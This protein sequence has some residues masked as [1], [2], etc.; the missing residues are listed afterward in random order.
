MQVFNNVLLPHLGVV[1]GIHAVVIVKDE[2]LLFI[3]YF[4]HDTHEEP[5]LIVI[6]GVE[7]HALF[8]AQWISVM[9]RLPKPILIIIKVCVS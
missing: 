9:L 8:E 5:A 1:P 7:S 4:L 2:A 3:E 6:L